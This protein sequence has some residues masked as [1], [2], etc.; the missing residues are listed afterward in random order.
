MDCMP[1]NPAARRYTQ[2]FFTT[3]S[4]YVVVLLSVV[5]CIKHLR[6]TGP[7]LYLLAVLPAV[8]ILGVIL[9][10]GLYLVE[11]KDEFQ[12]NVLIQSML[13]SIALKLATTTVWGFLQMF[14]GTIAFQPYLAFPLFWFFAGV[15]TPFLKRRY[16]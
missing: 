10:V 14:A 9:V 7:V 13:W 11:E 3:I 12:R 1:K 8:P 4:A 5:W 16:R 15:A 6:P 2:R